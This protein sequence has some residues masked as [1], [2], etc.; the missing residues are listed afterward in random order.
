M[1]VNYFDYG[2]T[3][4]KKSIGINFYVFC[5][6]VYDTSFE[7]EFRLSFF[8]LTQLSPAEYS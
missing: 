6:F 5:G 3:Y 1:Q 8:I 4:W 7:K 2:K